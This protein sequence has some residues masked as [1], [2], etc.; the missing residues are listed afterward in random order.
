M[1]NGVVGVSNVFFFA[2]QQGPGKCGQN[3]GFVSAV[4]LWAVNAQTR[5]CEIS[6]A[7]PIF[8][9]FTKSVLFFWL[10]LGRQKS[11][12]KGQQVVISRIT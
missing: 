2:V 7:V 12:Q 8:S 11:A 6:G 1:G 9:K 5:K 10:K 4:Y 3:V